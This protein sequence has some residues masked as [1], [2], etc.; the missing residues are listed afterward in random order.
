[1]PQQPF[2]APE[3]L[4]AASRKGDET[5]NSDRFPTWG[6]AG[7]STA[8]AAPDNPE[9]IGRYQVLRLL[10]QGSYGR[11]FLAR[12][13]E[14]SRDVAIKIPL[15]SR[16]AHPQ[17]V[18]A[19]LAEVGILAS[20]SHPSIVAVF[21]A[22]RTEYGHCFVVSKFIEGT[23]LARAMRDS[24]PSFAE[25]A[26][27]TA[28]VAETLHYAH[29]HGMVHRDVKPTNILIDADGQPI[30]ADFGLALKNDDFGKGSTFTGTPEYMRP[31][32]ARREAHQAAPTFSASA[33]SSTSS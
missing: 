10:G 3:D 11:V 8:T 32:Q 2:D 21:H 9:K 31:E 20:L 15:A 28:I 18:E 14:L 13:D 25:S 4:A 17:D 1:M 23:D 22:G 6:P 33:S 16:I 12:D 19:Y 27:L 24:R 5:A 29:R 30:L 7:T 26:R